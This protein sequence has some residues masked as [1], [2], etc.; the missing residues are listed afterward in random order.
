MKKCIGN[1]G[2]TLVEM[3]VT[4]TI[5]L[6]LFSGATTFFISFI[7]SQIKGKD[8]INILNENM[9]D[10]QLIIK[11]IKQA[12]SV[13][14]IDES[15]LIMRNTN[16]KLGPYSVV[17]KITKED[18]VY[19]GVYKD[20]L[21]IKD[22]F[23]FNDIVYDTN[24]NILYYS[25]TGNHVIR[26]V[27][28]PSKEITVIAGEYQVPGYSDE[29]KLLNMPMGLAL[30]QNS[31]LVIADYGN[32]RIRRLNQNGVME[33]IC[34]TGE[35]GYNESLDNQSC[36]LNQLNGPVDIEFNGDDLIFTDSNNNRVRSIDNDMKI[37]TIIDDTDHGLNRPTGVAYDKEKGVFVSDT[38]NNRVLLIDNNNNVSVYAGN[39]EQRYAGDDYKP[40]FASVSMPT[41]LVAFENT[42][43]IS[44]TMNH[45][46]RESNYD[47][48]IIRMKV[49]NSGRIFI[50]H[51]KDI[52]NPSDDIYSRLANPSPGVAE[53]GVPA[54]SPLSRLNNPT[55]IA[56][57]NEGNI[58]IMDSMN[59][60]IKAISG[61]DQSNNLGDTKKGYIYDFINSDFFRC[62]DT[63]NMVFDSINSYLGK[64]ELTNLVFD[65]PNT[66]HPQVNIR[67][68]LKKDDA[69]GANEVS[70]NLQTS[71]SLRNYQL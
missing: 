22:F 71:V 9:M 40:E 38:Y 65:I 69:R 5:M 14:K 42:L 43:L 26:M 16:Q 67:M 30:D 58:Y 35:P 47:D 53:D 21:A 41:G 33:T 68:R 54:L 13:K 10:M 61:S 8:Y 11:R 60:Q 7:N 44:D 50:N 18:E 56:V 2:F 66:Y 48:N 12:S 57:D 25:D 19:P 63:K 52:H 51:G 32:N 64:N 27:E 31:N 46:I 1:K 28:L 24:K 45:V 34:G 6:I 39:G 29:K 59:N 23:V 36:L 49:G 20:Q 3:I 17:T 55:G 37:H 4:V 70:S 15:T 62:I